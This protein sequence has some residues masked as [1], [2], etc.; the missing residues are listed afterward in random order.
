MD[1]ALGKKREVYA[2]KNAEKAHNTIIINA[3]WEVLTADR[4]I[5]NGGRAYMKVVGGISGLK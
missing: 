3:L 2:A 5:Y 4:S 1:K